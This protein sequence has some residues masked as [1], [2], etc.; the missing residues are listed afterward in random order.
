MKRRRF[1]P[2]ALFL[3]GCSSS[4]GD[5]SSPPAPLASIKG[6]LSVSSTVQATAPAGSI[7][8]ELAW[9]TPNS[10][11]VRIASQNVPVSTQLPAQFEIGLTGAPP[12]QAVWTPGN[13]TPSDLLWTTLH[14]PAPAA[15]QSFAIG[16]VLA[17]EDLNGNG[18]LDMV[19]VDATSAP[20][21]IVAADLGH[22]LFS[23]G[24]YGRV[25][26]GAPDGYVHIQAG[27]DD[28]GLASAWQPLATTQISVGETNDAWNLMMC[29][30]FNPLLESTDMFGSSWIGVQ[31]FFDAPV[32]TSDVLLPPANQ[33]LLSCS[34]GGTQFCIDAC[35]AP[36][37]QFYVCQSYDTDANPAALNDP[38]CEGRFGPIQQCFTMPSAP[39]AGWPC[40]YTPNVDCAPD[41][42]YDRCAGETFPPEDGGLPPPSDGG[43]F[44]GD[45]G[46]L[47]D[48]GGVF[49]SD[50]GVLSGDGG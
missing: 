20:D 29:T 27:D 14:L 38:Y 34:P 46:V 13:F 37:K 3:A 9:F 35:P 19:G 4:L 47:S 28:G 18:V 10:A 41:P 23:A 17:Y 45:G 22:I 33:P 43:G 44:S 11:A 16:Q 48:D 21:R 5:A 8:I 26:Y 12:A 1:L 2:F 30:N 39:P 40:T 32:W 36:N 31:S 6:T 25:S 24:G 50:G 42:Q 15:G 7:R 49:S